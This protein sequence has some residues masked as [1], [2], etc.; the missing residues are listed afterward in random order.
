MVKFLLAPFLLLATLFQSHQTSYTKMVD[1]VSPSLVYVSG[2]FQAGPDVQEY[3]C[4]GFVVAPD[5]E[6]TAKHCASH[7]M[8]VD[9]KEA[10]VLKVSDDLSDLALLSA[11]T[12]KPA[13]ALIE[14]PLALYQTAHAIGYAEGWDRFRVVDG[15]IQAYNY[16]PDSEKYAP[17]LFVGVAYIEG[18]SGGPV[19][20]DDGQVIGIVQQS[21]NAMGYGV[22]TLTIR[23]FLLGL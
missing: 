8:W 7:H 9:G 11:E 13:L 12:K 5:I 1:R 17:G 18:M 23:A 21:F 15:K 16:S 20:N 2:I 3:M 22:Q 14:E 6:L 4:T 19:V 10:K